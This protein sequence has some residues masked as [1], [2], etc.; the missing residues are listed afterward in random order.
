MEKREK[1]WIPLE[2]NPKVFTEYAEKLGCPTLMFKFH[3]VFG[4][5]DDVWSAMI[6]QPVQAV[7]LLYSIKKQHNDFIARQEKPEITADSPFFVKQK[8]HNACGTIALLHALLNSPSIIENLRDTSFL[9]EFYFINQTTT[10]DQ[11]ADHLNNDEK[12]EETH[13]TAALA[14][15]TQVHDDTQCHFVTYIQKD[16]FIWEMDGRL[17]APVK[18]NKIEEGQNLGIEASKII[19]EYMEMSG[20]GDIKFSVMAVAPNLGD[21]DF[22]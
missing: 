5:D 15:D 8:I 19:K 4:L 12:L 13:Q 3:D 11:R 9:Q 7:I 14:G 16:G 17:T 20:S 1:S 21:M 6:P 10:P 18:R 22:Y 2:G